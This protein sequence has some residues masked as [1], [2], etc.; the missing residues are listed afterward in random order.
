MHTTTDVQAVRGSKSITPWM[1][2]EARQKKPFD[3]AARASSRPPDR[4]RSTSRPDQAMVRAKVEMAA[5]N[6]R[7]TRARKG[8]KAMSGRPVTA[9]AKTKWVAQMPTPA[10]IPLR[11]SQAARTMPREPRILERR[12][13]R[14]N[15]AAKAP[16]AAV[17]TITVS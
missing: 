1:L 17:T 14:L 7:E 16:A 10:C 3:A 12:R 6:S 8:S 5:V 15:P 4:V 2:A 13:N 11:N 9:R